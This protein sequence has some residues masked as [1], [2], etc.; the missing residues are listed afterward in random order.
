MPEAEK[1]L[2][3]IE[4]KLDDLL[5]TNFT[6]KDMET[7]KVDICAPS[8]QCQGEMEKRLQKAEKFQARISGIVAAIT[9]IWGILITFIGLHHGR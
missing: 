8:R 6:K 3:R 4:N 5:E 2:E 7:F 9:A 1:R